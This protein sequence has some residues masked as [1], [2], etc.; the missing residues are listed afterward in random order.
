MSHMEWDVKAFYDANEGDRVGL[1]ALDDGH[2][3]VVW[4]Y[5]DPHCEVQMISFDPEQAQHVFDTS[6]RG[7]EERAGLRYDSR[8]EWQG[9]SL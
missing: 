4:A 3:A 5:A 8:Q 2:W 6:R 7:A 9:S 1:L